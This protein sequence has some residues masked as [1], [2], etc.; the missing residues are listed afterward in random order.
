MHYLAFCLVENVEAR[1]FLS[2]LNHVEYIQ[3][4]P[5]SNGMAFRFMLFFQTYPEICSLEIR[6]VYIFFLHR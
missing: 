5:R 3:P 4:A 6:V 1:L 2:I